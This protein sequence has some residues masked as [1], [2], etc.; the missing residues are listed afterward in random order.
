MKQRLRHAL[1]WVAVGIGFIPIILLAFAS[2][3]YD[4]L[5][6]VYSRLHSWCYQ[7]KYTRK[8]PRRPGEP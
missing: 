6:P 1:W 5:D 8:G 2:V 7:E 4:L 3:L